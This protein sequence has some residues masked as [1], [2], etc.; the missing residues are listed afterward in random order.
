MNQDWSSIFADKGFLSLKENEDDSDECMK[1]VYF[2][3]EMPPNASDPDNAD[4][5]IA[6]QMAVLSVADREK[7]YMD[8]HGLP[9]DCVHETTEL[10]KES[11]MKL[12]DE[13]D[14]LPDKKAYSIAEWLDPQFVHDQNFRLAFLRCTKFDC[15]KAAVRIIKHFQMK[16]ELFGED[17][18]AMEIVQDDLDA[19]AMEVLYSGASR[20][21]FGLDSGGR[22]I[23]INFNIPKTFT[24]DAMVSLCRYVPRSRVAWCP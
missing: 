3:Q 4:A 22:T 16:R 1:K 7:A 11:L 24:T 19:E 13:I 9:D 18:L 8:V 10:T 21:L 23:N 6:A 15:Q 5:L 14:G 17:K 2:S 20:Y 12:Q